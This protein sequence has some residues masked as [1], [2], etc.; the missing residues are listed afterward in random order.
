MEKSGDL[1][2]S[3]GADPDVVDFGFEKVSPSEKNRRVEGVFRSVAVRY[4]VM[5]DLMSFGLHRLFKRMV[6]E[7]SSVRR[8]DRILDLAG[9]TGDLSALFT[10]IVGSQGQVILSDINASMMDIGRDQ[11][12]NKGIIEVQYCQANAERLPFDN[13]SFNCITIG[14]GLR[15]I[16]HKERALSEMLRVLKPGGRLLV[17]EFSKPQTPIIDAAYSGFQ[18]LWPTIGKLI[19]GDASAYKYLI[20]SIKVHPNQKALK[21]MIG[22]AGFTSVSYHN[23]LDGIVAI[24][25]AI[26]EP[27]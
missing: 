21:Q 7:M 23:L 13:D 1:K 17:L 20:E 12:L 3:P 5:N 22:D 10:P 16:T 25:R 27:I 8:G 19:T 18:A 4:D 11:L 6:I 24:H 14:F 2:Q 26:K 15:N 9:G